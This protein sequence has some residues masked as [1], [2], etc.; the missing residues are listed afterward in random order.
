[1]N[2][3]LV[4]WFG[5]SGVVLASILGLIFINTMWGS[6]VLFRQY[7]TGEKQ[8]LYLL[9]LLFY[10]VVTVLTCVAASWLCGLLPVDGVLGLMLRGILCGVV[11]VTLVPALLSRLPEFRSALHMARRMAHLAD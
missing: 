2:F 4:R 1:M 8:A 5:V 11:A 7:F 9:R 6:R 10:G 3:L